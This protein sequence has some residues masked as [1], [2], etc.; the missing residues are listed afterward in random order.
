[1]TT[2]PTVSRLPEVKGWLL[3]DTDLVM[4]AA[5]VVTVAVLVRFSSAIIPTKFGPAS[6]AAN[7]AS[8]AVLVCAVFGTAVAPISSS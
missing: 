4:P 7:R 1:M 8:V 5:A 6:V 2:S 3:E